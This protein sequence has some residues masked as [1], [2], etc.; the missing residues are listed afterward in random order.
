MQSFDFLKRIL[1]RYE[2]LPEKSWLSYLTCCSFKQLNKGDILYSLGEQPKSFAFLNKGLMR[3]YVIDDKGN[4]F[5]KNFFA[6][7]RFPGCMTA[8]LTQTPSFI[9]IQALEQCD[10]I[11]INFKRFR[12]LLLNDPALMRLHISYLE[13]HW[14]LEKEPKEI[15]Y[16]QNEAKQRYRVFLEDYAG[17]A[18]RLSQYH[19]AGYLGI[20]PTQLSRIKKQI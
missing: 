6:E 1:S 7:G 2:K 9:E 12:K 8:L 11:E 10:I 18:T 4:E 15:G 5:N 3:A 20:T 14:L 17:I 16:L 19:I 13:T